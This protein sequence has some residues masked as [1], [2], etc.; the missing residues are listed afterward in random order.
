MATATSTQWYE[1]RRYRAVAL[2]EQGWKQCEIAAALGVTRGAVS[3][4]M[5]LAY[6]AGPTALAAQPH[7]G[8][9]RRLSTQDLW[10]LPDLLSHGAEAYGFSG[11]LWTCRRV[12][13]VIEQEFGVTYDRKH[14]ARLLKQ[15]GWTPQKPI[16]RASQRDETAIGAWRTD[17]AGGKKRAR[18][19]RRELVFIDESGYYLLPFVA[20]TYAPMGCTPILKV[21]HTRDHLS[22]MSGISPAGA[23]F[24]MI[25]GEA[26]DGEAAVA[27]LRHV[28]RCVDRKLLVVWDGSPIHRGR[29]MRD[30]LENGAARHIHLEALPPYAPD[31]TRMKACGVTPNAS[32]CAMCA[33]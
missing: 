33:A 24:T 29:T 15:I 4:W 14:V 19:E 32:N 17:V 21:K 18:L 2:H 30:F 31:S 25:R 27:F 6:E 22:I 9:P 5:K 11:E 13:W 10:L 28:R 23:L 20:R 1:A 16:V 8:A 3:Q 7:S 26:L 12:K